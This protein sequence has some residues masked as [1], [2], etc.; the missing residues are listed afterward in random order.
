MKEDQL[1]NDGREREA[2]GANDIKSYLESLPIAGKPAFIGSRKHQPSYADSLASA[3]PLGFGSYQPRSDVIDSKMKSSAAAVPVTATNGIPTALGEQ[4]ESP[5][6]I[7][8]DE[9]IN[10]SSSD[11]I[12][13]VTD[14]MATV[15]KPPRR[16]VTVSVDHVISSTQQEIAKDVR[17]N[18]EFRNSVESIEGEDKN[19]L[20]SHEIPEIESPHTYSDFVAF[21]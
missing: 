17:G 2:A 18:R 20:L 12:T 15:Q 7:N 11:A 16:K 21:F 6:L 9:N 19:S 1:A 10:D 8:D 14:S 5:V 4:V 13:D 3:K